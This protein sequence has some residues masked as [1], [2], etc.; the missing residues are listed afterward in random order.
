M[1]TT[2]F[3]LLTVFVACMMSMPAAAQTPQ[4]SPTDIAHMNHLKETLPGR[5][6]FFYKEGQRPALFTPDFIKAHADYSDVDPI[7]GA[8]RNGN[9]FDPPTPHCYPCATDSGWFLVDSYLNE[10]ELC[11]PDEDTVCEVLV[12][13]ELYEDVASDG[14]GNVY[15]TYYETDDIVQYEYCLPIDF[16]CCDCEL[17]QM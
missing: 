11:I 14:N 4:M 1:K 9:H 6:A 13:T 3:L 17:Y 5:W 2:V 7:T 15:T 16:F 8:D 10:E 12:D